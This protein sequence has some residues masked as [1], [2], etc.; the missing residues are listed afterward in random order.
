MKEVIIVG[1]G[2]IGICCALELRKQGCEVMLIDRGSPGGGASS[3]NAGVISTGGIAPYPGP[4]MLSTMLRLGFNR[5]P[6]VK[7]HWP[8]FF[9]LLPNLVRFL[10]HC[11]HESYAKGVTALSYLLKDAVELHR[12]LLEESGAETLLNDTGWLRLYRTE[13]AFAQTARERTNYDRYG[14]PYQLLGAQEIREL[15]PDIALAYHRAIWLTRTPSVRNPEKLCL[16][17]FDRYR[18]LGGRFSSENARQLTRKGNQ[19]HLATAAGVLE[20]SDVLVCM[21]AHSNHLLSTIG[22]KIPLSIERGYH[23]V[24]PPA[25]GKSLARS[26][27]DAEQGLCM[28]PMDTGIRVT[29]AVN[30]VAK[31]T[32]PHYDQILNLVP[33]IERIF[34]MS[35]RAADKPWMGR[36][37]STPDSLPVIGPVRAHSGL[38][39]A[40]GHQHL[41]L[42]AGPKTGKLV[43]AQMLGK[44]VDNEASAFS[45][46]R[47]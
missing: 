8:H 24:Y 43:A 15:E 22:L 41:G 29:S 28:T 27:L 38:W 46:D 36:R 35:K 23:L 47:F 17:Y 9:E 14:V 5:D 6:R 33:Q 3:G 31:D 1:A 42:T 44:P 13:E 12:E 4:G 30:I 34:P 40:L 18:S 45:P 21:G 37:P 20:T 32:D 19:W 16:A 26:V 25:E 10:R 39:L 7:F 2:I 11:N